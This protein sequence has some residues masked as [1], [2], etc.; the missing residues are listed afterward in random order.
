MNPVST[1]RFRRLTG[2]FAV[3]F[4]AVTVFA[5]AIHLTPA[6]GGLV[7][8]VK[9][10][11]LGGSS[12]VQTMTREAINA[13]VGVSDEVVSIDGT[14]MLRVLRRP[15]GLLVE[16]QTNRYVFERKDDST[17]SVDLHPAPSAFSRHPLDLLLDASLLAVSVFYL[18]VGA[19]VWRSRSER[20][21]AWAFMLF[22]GAISAELAAWARV[23]VVPYGALRMVA[24]APWLGATAFHLFT[25]YP[26]EPEWIVRH[27]RIRLL[28]YLGAIA[29]SALVLSSH[30]MAPS[31]EIGVANFAFAYGMGL[32]VVSLCVLA[33]ERQNAR[34]A[35]VGD[36]V[37]LVLV[38]GLASFAPA[39]LIVFAEYYLATSFP[40]YLALLWIVFLPAAI[41][42]GMLRR[43][44]FELRLLAKSSAAYGAAT[45]SITGLFALMITFADQAA[46]RLGMTMQSAQVVFL[47]LAIL[48]F[49]PLRDR[50]QRLVDGIFDRDRSRYRSAVREISEAMVSMLSLREIGDRILAA[51]T[52][53]MGVERA[54]VMLFDEEDRMLRPSVWRGD[55]EEDERAELEIPAEHPIWRHL[56]MRREELQRS[57]FDEEPDPEKR[58][59]CRDVFDSLEVELV[60]PVL[61]GVDLLGV[62]AVGRKLSGEPLA[63]DDRQLLRTLANQSAIAMENAKAFDEIAKLNETLEARVE[64]RTAE[65]QDIQVQLMQSEKMSSLGQLV[66]GVAHELNNPI[67]FVHANLQLLDEFIEKLAR[68]QAEGQDTEKIREAINKLLMRSREGTHRVKEIVQDLRTFSRMDQAELQDADLHEELDRTIGLMEPRF[69][70]GV[71]IV[72]D[73]GDLPRVR[74]YPG[75]LNQVFLNL[76]MN[77]CD[78]MD[79]R[80]SIEI[81]TRR[82][83]DGV[84]LEFRDDGPGIP[85]ELLNRL[86]EPFFTTKEVGKGTG[87]GLSLSHGIIERHG[88]RFS[89]TSN[90]GEGSSFTIELPLD[91]SPLAE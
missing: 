85:P 68:A 9:I 73:Y 18:V 49:N 5:T 16:G 72:R 4:A 52:D 7:L 67:G 50:L 80:G 78:A 26:L 69:K 39:M 76:L 61:F 6:D 84:R 75:Q 19:M 32:C 40:P 8:P 37:D 71:T 55:W 29:L 90:L 83:A 41:G 20:A 12:T 3:A 82:T 46:Q 15:E 65:L 33:S 91:A 36:R 30:L 35:G 17:Y 60:V 45:L 14:P 57:D 51:L 25:T 87:L 48:A 2:L 21:E 31:V 27:R 81:V 43:R 53:T 28:P 24:N 10:A 74:C 86:F 13:G 58:E 34:L 77:A 88:G 1:S 47:F 63:A 62:I 42:I 64:A 56:W 89:V 44:R 70:D 54:M 38:A 23:D 59:Q 66:A 79:S 22:C 11:L